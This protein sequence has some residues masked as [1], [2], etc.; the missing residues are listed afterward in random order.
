M[1]SS[2]ITYDMITLQ[3]RKVSRHGTAKSPTK[4]T[5]RTFLGRRD[6]CVHVVF[7]L[8]ARQGQCLNMTFLPSSPTSVSMYRGQ[9]KYLFKVMNLVQPRALH[10]HDDKRCFMLSCNTCNASLVSLW[11]FSSSERHWRCIFVQNG[12]FLNRDGRRGVK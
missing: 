10:L 7:L 2:R 12:L 3:S 11:P 4:D 9:S 1:V 6:V 8:A 5:I